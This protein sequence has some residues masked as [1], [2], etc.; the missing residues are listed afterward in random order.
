MAL[1]V[2][3]TDDEFTKELKEAVI[4]VFVAAGVQETGFNKEGMVKYLLGLVQAGKLPDAPPWPS[5]DAEGIAEITSVICGHV[6]EMFRDGDKNNDG[7]VNTGEAFDFILE[8]VLQANGVESS[9]DLHEEKK[10]Y[11]LHAIRM[12][13]DKMSGAAAASGEDK[14]NQVKDKLKKAFDK[15]DVNGDG[16]LDREEMKAGCLVIAKSIAEMCPGMPG[17]EDSELEAALDGFIAESCPDGGKI[18]FDAML[19]VAL[20]NLCGSSPGEDPVEFFAKIDQC[21]FTTIN[22]QIDMYLG[23]LLK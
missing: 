9:A 18:S 3:N 21:M 20:P 16:V 23:G 10:M 13:S 22:M 6:D 14:F 15:C 19:A 2:L 17:G 11:A 12:Y 5:E 7:K 8:K 4:K 1:Q